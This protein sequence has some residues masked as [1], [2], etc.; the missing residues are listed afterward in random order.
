[1]TAAPK[2]VEPG[3]YRRG[4]IDYASIDAVNFSTLKVL[5][6]SA[7]HYRHI[8]DCGMETSAPMRL[9][10]AAHTATLDPVRF[11]RDYAVYEPPEDKTDR[12]GTKAWK[13]F[14]QA[15]A[16]KTILKDGEFTEAMLIRDAVR[17]DKLAMRYLRKGEAEQVMVWIDKETG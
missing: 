7:L 16:G 15:N 14:E 4:S 12:R 10:E 6:K 13:A 5:A 2:I 17:S 11:T 9:G 1:M 3:I 8:V